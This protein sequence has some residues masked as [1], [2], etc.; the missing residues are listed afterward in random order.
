MLD[1]LRER[2]ERTSEEHRA[3]DLRCTDAPTWLRR[4]IEGLRFEKA[5]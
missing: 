2:V 5:H 4:G 1:A 3:F